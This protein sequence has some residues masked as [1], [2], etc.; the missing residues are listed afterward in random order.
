MPHLVEMAEKW[1]DKGVVVISLHVETM[2]DVEEG[3][4]KSQEK[5][6]KILE[7]LKMKGPNYYLAESQ[8]LWMERL[9]I[10]GYPAVFVFNKAGRIARKFSDDEEAKAEIP[11]LLPKLTEEK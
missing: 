1:R 9:E 11:N 4:E 10:E 8:A 3:R 7:R 5:A 6:R 2:L